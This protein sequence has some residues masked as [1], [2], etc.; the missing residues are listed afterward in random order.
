MI[1]AHGPSE[2]VG[3]FTRQVEA[4]YHGLF[5]WLTVYFAEPIKF[6]L[7]LVFALVVNLWLA[8]ACLFFALLV[9]LIGGRIAASFRLRSRLAM[10]EAAEQLAL[11][12]ESLMMMRLVKSYQ[13]EALQPSPRRASDCPPQQSTSV[14]QMSDDVYQPILVF[15]GTFAALFSPVGRRHPSSESAS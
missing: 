2:A 6:G 12:Q 5:V 4:V 3:V 14:R 1:K 11:V 8:L 13:M 7:I 15:L 10:Q 9:W